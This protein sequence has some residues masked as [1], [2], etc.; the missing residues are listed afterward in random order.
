MHQALQNNNLEYIHIN[1]SE[2]YEREHYINH[3]K[4]GRDDP[5]H[6]LSPH[7]CP[8]PP[9]ITTGIGIGEETRRKIT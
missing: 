6:G 8:F 1:D 7:L 3:L 9:L 2:R 4:G 5:Q